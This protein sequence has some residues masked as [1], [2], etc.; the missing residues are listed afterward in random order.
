MAPQVRRSSEISGAAREPTTDMAIDGEGNNVAELN[1]GF[2]ELG[3]NHQRRGR[4]VTINE[5]LSKLRARGIPLDLHFP[6]QFGKVCGRH[7]SVFKSEVTVCIRQEASLRVM[8]WKDMDN[9]FPGTTTTIWNFLRDKFPE[10]SVGDKGYV[11]AQVEHQYN[12]WSETNSRNRG[13]QEMKSLVGTKSIVQIAYEQRDP[14]TS[15]WPTAM[16]LYKA[17]YQKP[18]GTWSVQNGEEILNNLHT[19]AETEQEKI[20]SAPVPFVEHFALVLGR[21]SNHSWGVGVAEVNHGAQERHMLHAQ[22]EAARQHADDAQ[23]HAAALQGEVLR[24]TEVNNQL[25]DELQSQREELISQ[26]RTVE[27]QSMDTE[28][29]VDQKLEEGM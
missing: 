28:R 13:Q 21:K 3:R 24:L 19:V 12:K 23:E 16:D 11:M 4:G 6:Q 25:R 22:A 15:E 20:A 26:R 14:A 10:I 7:A 1:P 29:L 8:K 2:Y 17:I 5:K 9:A 18:D 27:E